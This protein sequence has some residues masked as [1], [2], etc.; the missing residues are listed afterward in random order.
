[1][2]CQAGDVVFV[3]VFSLE[4][5]SGYVTSVHLTEEAAKDWC[6]SNI[7]ATINWHSKRTGS[8]VLV[9]WTEAGTGESPYRRGVD[10]AIEEHPIQDIP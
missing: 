10:I 7:G 5:G 3:V 6:A 9:G 2:A 1:M 4:H 8:V